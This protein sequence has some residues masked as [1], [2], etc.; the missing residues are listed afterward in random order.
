M[1]FVFK[2]INYYINNITCNKNNNIYNTNNN[3]CN[4]N[5]NVKL[6]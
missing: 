4:I 1:I 5:N 6:V 3:I 2:F